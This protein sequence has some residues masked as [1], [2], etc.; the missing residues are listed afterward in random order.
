MGPTVSLS[1][2]RFAYTL[3]NPN[4]TPNLPNVRDV[5]GN[6]K[7]YNM[8]SDLIDYGGVQILDRTTLH[9]GIK[10]GINLTCTKSLS[11]FGFYVKYYYETTS[12]HWE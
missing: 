1:F 10:I 7:H 4:S 8:V 9:Q 6:I 5:N 2:L 12:N 3:T 11:S